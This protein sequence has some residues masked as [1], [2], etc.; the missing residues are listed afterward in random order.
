MMDND[1]YSK[2]DDKARRL[3]WIE[4]YVASGEF[5][6]ALELGWVGWDPGYHEHD[7]GVVHADVSE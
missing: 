7:S 5:E 2:T 3:L 6:N 1:S 4:Y